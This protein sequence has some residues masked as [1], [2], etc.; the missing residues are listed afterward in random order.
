[1][2][3]KFLLVILL[4]LSLT[5]PAVGQAT[6]EEPE[7][8]RNI[9]RLLK[10]TGTEKLQQGMMD[11]MLAAVKSATPPI[12]DQNGKKMIDRLT[13][14]LGEEFKKIGFSNMAIELYDKYFS[15][16][17]IKGLIQF[18]ESPV[19]QKAIEVL[20]GLMQEST[21][22][23]MEMGNAAGMKSLER[24]LEEFPDLKKIVPPVRD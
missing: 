21:S 23:G 2:K 19:G 3:S 24:W 13:E 16:E 1:M 8:V 6:K 5:A 17:E 12:P 14:I 20:P 11:Q 7:K 10:M 9:R 18:Y 15:A 22:R 4:G